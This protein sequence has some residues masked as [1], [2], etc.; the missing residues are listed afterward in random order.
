VVEDIP[1]L[2]EVARAPTR[3]DGAG[4]EWRLLSKRVVKD[5]AL[6]GSGLQPRP[7]P[8]VPAEAEVALEAELRLSRLFVGRVRIRGNQRRRKLASLPEVPRLASRLQLACTPEQTH[9]PYACQ[10]RLRHV[11]G[12]ANASRPP[13]GQ[14]M[15]F[16]CKHKPICA[17]SGYVAGL[18]QGL[19]KQ[20]RE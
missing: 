20:S 11:P 13:A 17:Y 5:R 18:R 15:G 16:L 19:T 12:R 2:C 7:C 8:H 10:S 9:L 4:R 14:R 3:V 1:E 6:P